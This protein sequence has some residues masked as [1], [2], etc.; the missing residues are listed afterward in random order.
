MK[1]I[2]H[3]TI[4]NSTGSIE[5]IDLEDFLPPSRKELQYQRQE[6]YEYLD[7]PLISR[8]T[9]FQLCANAIIL[10]RV[11]NV[12]TRF[13]IPVSAT[14]EYSVEQGKR[15]QKISVSAKI[16]FVFL[17]SGEIDYLSTNKLIFEK[18]NELTQKAMVIA[19][20]FKL[21]HLIKEIQHLEK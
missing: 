9:R 3:L 6:I 2:A 12:P 1:N 10:H 5:L 8:G 15:F 7:I 13:K 21:S 17:K 19:R 11:L 4:V 18:Y 16:Q 20:K 14:K